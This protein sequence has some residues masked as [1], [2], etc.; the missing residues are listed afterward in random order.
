M[1][2]GVPRQPATGTGSE[3]KGQEQQGGHEVRQ[4]WCSMCGQ[5][6]SLYRVGW[7]WTAASQADH[8]L[9][10]DGSPAAGE[11]TGQLGEEA[12]AMRR[13]SST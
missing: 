2:A 13:G 9:A 8:R 1:P 11:L 3:V 10:G 6:A 4:G 7:S 12:V 5:G